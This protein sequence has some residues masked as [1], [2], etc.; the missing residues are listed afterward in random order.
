MGHASLVGEAIDSCLQAKPRPEQ[1]VV[2]D[3]ASDPPVVLGG[4]SETPGLLFQRFDE[5]AGRSAAR[6]HAV[7]NMSTTPWLYFLDAD[8][9]LMPTAIHDFRNVMRRHPYV[10]LIW[11]DYVHST[12]RM[13]PGKL[14]QQKRFRRK[15][16]HRDMRTITMA[17][18]GLF[19]Q[20]A[21][22]EAI[23]GF[24]VGLDIGEDRD[25][26]S[27]YAFNIRIKL[28][29]HDRPFVRTRWGQHALPDAGRLYGEG[30]KVINKRFE[31]GYYNEW[32][33]R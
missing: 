7:L 20:R 19:V 12:I 5:H 2:V 3:D 24:E 1:I 14:C 21:R 25:F 33:V 30:M 10:Q 27:R 15:T 29:K 26:F 22:F 9:W 4:L 13:G 28:W 16:L 31:D 11:A 18:I 32:A 8:D 17:H 23:G 6:N